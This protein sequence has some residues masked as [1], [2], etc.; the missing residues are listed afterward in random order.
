M[1]E[2]IS[3][4]KPSIARFTIVQLTETEYRLLWSCHHILLD[5]FATLIIL[6]DVFTI[7]EAL[8]SNAP[9]PLAPVPSYQDFAKWMGQKNIQEAEAFWGRHLSAFL[10]VG[11]FNPS[12]NPYP[13]AKNFKSEQLN[14]SGAKSNVLKQKSKE[15]GISLNTLLQSTWAIILAKW[16]DTNDL[17]YGLTVSG[18]TNNFLGIERLAHQV[19]NVVPVRMKTPPN[20]SAEEWLKGNQSLLNEIGTYE[21]LAMSQINQLIS[22]EYRQDLFHSLVVFQGLPWEKLEKG[23]LVISNVRGKTTSV[24]PITL[25][26]DTNGAIQFTV[27][28]DEHQNLQTF[29]AW[30]IRQ[31]ES[32][33]DRLTNTSKVSLENI[34]NSLENSLRASYLVPKKENSLEKGHLAKS[35]TEIQLLNIWKGV[36]GKE[37]IAVTDDFFEIGGTSIAAV[38]VFNQISKQFNQKFAP[39]SLMTHPTITSLAKLLEE[40]N[41]TH[42]ASMV[43]LQPLGT[44]PPLFVLHDIGGDLFIYRNLIEC[45]GKDQPVYGFQARSL[46]DNASTLESVSDLA[47]YYVQEILKIFPN[48]P[49]LLGGISYGGILAYEMS[50]K[51]VEAN[52]EVDLLVLF[53]TFPNTG[54]FEK[55]DKSAPLSTKILER[56][57]E[58]IGRLLVEG[59]K[60][61]FQNY[62]NAAIKAFTKRVPFL[63]TKSNIPPERNIGVWRANEKAIDNYFIE[64]VDCRITLLMARKNYARTYQDVRLNWHNFARKGLEVHL[65]PGNHISMMYPPNTAEVAK[66]LARC[67]DR[68]VDQKPLTK[69]S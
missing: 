19:M 64:P 69:I 43:A 28:Y 52:K 50:R 16:F 68:V 46:T 39:V 49:Y 5:G 24:Y 7:Y 12:P 33:I 30:A 53:D 55:R 66:T 21:Y 9:N 35:A 65:V 34:F 61:R 63:K 62:F 1:G 17:V 25:M 37:A 26:I 51:F 27:R 14:L 8:K 41:T 2:G 38:Q 60:K 42:W 15:W 57:D 44:K 10:P 13:K 23:G 22:P 45:L 56:I 20:I 54:D 32:I 40:N 36:L 67:I 31:M 48:G 58:H 18:R 29:A 47:D 11:S 59:S 6:E 4:T 3:F